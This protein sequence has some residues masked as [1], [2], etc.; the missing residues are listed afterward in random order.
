MKWNMSS[1]VLSLLFIT[2]SDSALADISSN[3]PYPI[4]DIF[5]PPPK[6]PPALPP[7]LDLPLV[8]PIGFLMEKSLEKCVFSCLENLDGENFRMYQYYCIEAFDLD[9]CD[10]A[11]EN[12]GLETI[13][14]CKDECRPRIPVPAIIPPRQGNGE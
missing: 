6:N 13:N 12:L 1:I 7:V 9:L 10:Q 14:K 2:F 8:N 4:H 11:V 3:S 5:G